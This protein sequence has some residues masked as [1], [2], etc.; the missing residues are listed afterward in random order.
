MRPCL[1][2]RPDESSRRT[3]LDDGGRR[4]FAIDQIVQV[5]GSLLILAAFV[6]AQRGW[7]STQSR[8]YLALNLVGA[9]VLTVLAARE[10]QFGFLLLELVWAVVAAHALV[11]SFRQG[12]RLT[13]GRDPDA[14]RCG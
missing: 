11:A 5:L 3:R 10:R 6:A 7:L 4:R 12:R 2:G 8:R 1:G 9:S 14:Q 13:S